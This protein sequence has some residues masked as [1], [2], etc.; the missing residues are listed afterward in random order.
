MIEDFITKIYPAAKIVE[1]A[2]GI[3]WRFAMVQAYHESRHGESLLTKEANN[4]FGITGDT[5]SNEGKPVYWIE[6]T[7]Y[8]KEKIP[9]K[10]RRPFRKYDSWQASL[11]D[12]AGLIERRYAAALAAARNQDF[13]GFAKSLQQGGYATDPAYAMQLVRLNQDLSIRA[14]QVA[15]AQVP[16]A[17][18]LSEDPPK[19]A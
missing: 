5:W 12:W 17:P 6:T 3:P 10:I 13:V 7:E 2:T 18:P 4:L 8:N 1:G 19:T 9:F 11:E 14:E 16:P 15:Q